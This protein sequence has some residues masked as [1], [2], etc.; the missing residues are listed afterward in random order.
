M[1]AGNFGQDTDALRIPDL[2]IDT[3]EFH[4]KINHRVTAGLLEGDLIPS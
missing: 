2:F 4:T 3:G 1:L